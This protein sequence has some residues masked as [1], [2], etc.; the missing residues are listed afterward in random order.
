MLTEGEYAVAMALA[1]LA[2]DEDDAAMVTMARLGALAERSERWT[3]KLVRALE[4]Y[5]VL[6][7][8]HQQLGVR[9]PKT[10]Y[11]FVELEDTRPHPKPDTVNIIS[12]AEAMRRK[13]EAMRA[14]AAKQGGYVWGP[15]TPVLFATIYE[16]LQRAQRDDARLRE[17]DGRSGA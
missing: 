14:R 2:R 16:E 10:T 4:N 13:A 15:Y 8:Q 12:L 6:L 5:G 7:T 3:R 11:R 17:A 1:R 9:W